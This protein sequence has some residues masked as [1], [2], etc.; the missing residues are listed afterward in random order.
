M[1]FDT[2]VIAYALLGVPG[3]GDDCLGALSSAR[4]VIVPDLFFAELANVVWLWT[5]KRGLSLDEGVQM[6]RRAEAL[7][8]KV[9]PG[10][11][12]WEQAL[13]LSTESSHPVY[14]TLFVALAAREGTCVVTCDGRML[15]RFPGI[16]RRP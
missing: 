12:V 4:E 8:T 16:A 9:V 1:V 3:F 13:L 14:D 7:V 11:S 15:D 10:R 6:L 5:R 2:M